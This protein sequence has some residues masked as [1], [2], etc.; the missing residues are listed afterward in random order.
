[1]RLLVIIP[2]YNEIENIR[3]VIRE[4][5]NSVSGDV[6]CNILIVDDNSPDKTAD[7]VK[8]LQEE[9]NDR[10]YLLL[11]KG[12]EG[13]ASA[14]IDGFSWGIERN[15]DYFLEMDADFSHDPKYINTMLE[16]IKTYDFV[17]GSR[18]I[19]G[20]GVEGWPF[21]RHILS[22][23]GSFYSR[24]ILGCPIK[25]LTNGFN[26]WRK[27]TIEGIGLGTIISKGFSFLLE[28]KY[29]AYK[30]GYKYI[31]IPIILKNRVLGESKMSIKI[32]S[33]ALINIW[34]IKYG[35]EKSV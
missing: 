2:T 6:Q 13:F 22:K 30:K 19:E 33:E 5:F 32:F 17:I 25:D 27:E 12:K 18:N 14:Y 15:Y 16:E 10:L 31:E 23:G 9:Y 11:R 8:A 28:K 24:L 1:M 34:K 7:A 26:M 29:R 21:W 4:V 3:D 35:K 20:G